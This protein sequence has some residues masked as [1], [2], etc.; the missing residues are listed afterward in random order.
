MALKSLLFFS[1]L[2]AVAAAPVAEAQLGNIIGSILD[3]IRIQG[4]LFC[5]ANGNMGVNGTATPVF[6]N[7]PV[8]LQCGAGNVI[9]SATTNSA[10]LF[11]I[12]L[13][14]LQF[15]LSSLLTNCNLVVNTPLSTCNSGLPS[16]GALLSPLRLI[17]NTLQGPLHITNIIPANFVFLPHL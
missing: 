6:P 9:S 15:L 4:N 7:A 5:T 17:G 1:L 8:Q 3:L 16:S 2:V 13:D 11:S 14:P 10:G 12:L